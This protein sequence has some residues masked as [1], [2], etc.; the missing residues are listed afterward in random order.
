MVKPRNQKTARTR[1]PETLEERARHRRDSGSRRSPADPKRFAVSPVP[2]MQPSP[3]LPP[4]ASLAAFHILR[5]Q[6]KA[7]A[8]AAQND[9]D[10]LQF[11]RAR[12]LC[13]LLRISKPTLWR[14]RRR[15]DFPR[16]TGV[17]DR[18]VAWRRAEVEQWLSTRLEPARRGASV[19]RIESQTR[20]PRATVVTENTSGASRLPSEP[21]TDKQVAARRSR[22]PRG[23]PREN[24]QLELPLQVF[25]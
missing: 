16:P 7:E 3:I 6:G 17:T 14:L 11:L 25:D 21:R 4:A 1:R 24:S 18:V 15:R 23:A 10:A 19:T 20:S 12:D 2:L 22:V 9:L 5:A 13:K 8:S